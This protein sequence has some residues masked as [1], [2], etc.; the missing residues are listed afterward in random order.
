MSIC[1][2]ILSL[3]NRRHI[4]VIFHEY[5]IS[6]ESGQETQH[7]LNPRSPAT[8]F[9]PPSRGP[10]GLECISSPRL[11]FFCWNAAFE[12]LVWCSVISGLLAILMQRHLVDEIDDIHV[13]DASLQSLSQFAAR[14]KPG[15]VKC[16]WGAGSA[17][18]LYFHENRKICFTHSHHLPLNCALMRDHRFSA[19]SLVLPWRTW[20]SYQ[21]RGSMHARWN[22]TGPCWKREGK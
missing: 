10:H 13:T 19:P 20:V 9:P 12:L 2:S 22:Q 4:P 16:R 5:L 11:F 14:H 1:V 6:P 8:M 17:S 15:W 21:L 7:G 3:G 18:A